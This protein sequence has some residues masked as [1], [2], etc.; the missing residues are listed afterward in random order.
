MSV[1]SF[2]SEFI[3]FI[4]GVL[5]AVGVVQAPIIE[6]P[7][8]TALKELVQVNMPKA[9]P[10]TTTKRVEQ[11]ATATKK[12]PPTCK[13]SSAPET[14]WVGQQVKLSWTST[15]ATKAS[16][17]LPV[18]KPSNPK[19]S[20]L[21]AT[22]S[23]VYK[24]EGRGLYR[25]V[26]NVSGPEGKA[27]CET[28]VRSAP[29]KN[30]ESPTMPK[31]QSL[32]TKREVYFREVQVGDVFDVDD[33]S[34]QVRVRETIPDR[35]YGIPKVKVDIIEGGATRTRIIDYLHHALIG[36]YRVDVVES[37]RQGV[38]TLKLSPTPEH[39]AV[40]ALLN[41]SNVSRTFQ[42]G[43][44]AHLEWKTIPFSNNTT[45]TV[46]VQEQVGQQGA[47]YLGKEMQGERGD[48][49][50]EPLFGFKGRALYECADKGA[51]TMGSTVIGF[52]VAVPVQRPSCTM[53][54]EVSE[55]YAGQ[56]VPI[57]IQYSNAHFYDFD[58]GELKKL[59][60]PNG[61]INEEVRITSYGTSVNVYN[62]TQEATCTFKP[63]IIPKMPPLPLNTE[64]YYRGVT[65]PDDRRI[66]DVMVLQAVLSLYLTEQK[67]YPAATTAEHLSR[68]L[69]SVPVDPITSQPYFYD[70]LE[71][72]AAYEI[73]ANLDSV[74]SPYFGSDADS[75]P[76]AGS[77]TSPSDAD[78]CQGEQGRYCLDYTSTH[79]LR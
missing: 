65:T 11:K 27:Q 20:D 54:S 45:C 15:N 40:D 14:T 71:N 32:N 29:D 70:L 73:G 31:T 18:E 64:L 26:L 61:S 16:L 36:T 5:V 9:Q 78:G 34:A 33:K 79:I 72:G 66:R 19:T 6:I 42:A 63:K 60:D 48:V 57:V 4:T 58:G 1:G 8:D 62:G 51:K 17:T 10:A 44:R 47:M 7:P 13:L 46:V 24:I 75:P 39:L 23:L 41:G 68:Y 2:V 28:T 55:G 38:S 21:P 37:N 49:R 69:A 22:G 74:S 50:S 77:L 56:S 12:G 35:T 30:S 43:E 67:K 25:F 3:S 59:T 53:V 52:D 76:S